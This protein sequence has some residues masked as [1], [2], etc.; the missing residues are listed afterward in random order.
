LLNRHISAI[1][2]QPV[3]SESGQISSGPRPNR[4]PSADV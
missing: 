2:G 4:L 1:S 3:V